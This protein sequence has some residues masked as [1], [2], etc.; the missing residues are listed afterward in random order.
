MA[1]SNTER[2]RREVGQVVDRR[3][4]PDFGGDPRN[5]KQGEEQRDK[6]KEQDGYCEK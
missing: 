6:E 1:G 4:V 3:T 5:V 2:R